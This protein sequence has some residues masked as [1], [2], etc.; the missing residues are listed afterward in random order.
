LIELGLLE[1]NPGYGHPLRP[2]FRL[3]RLGRRIAAIA[4][5]I[6]DVSQEEDWPLLRRSWTL[7]V[8]TL[9]HEPSHFT[10]MK[11]HLPTITDRALSQSLKS[12]EARNWVCRSVDGVARPPRSIY[13]SANTGGLISQVIA[14]EVISVGRS[15]SD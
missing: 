7:P 13:R 14:P 4:A 11:R 5:R 10:E 2:E 9:L 1:R 12:M 15:S 8:L 3:T 6:H